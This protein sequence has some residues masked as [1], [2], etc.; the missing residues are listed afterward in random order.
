MHQSGE[1]WRPGQGRRVRLFFLERWGREEA[2]YADVIVELTKMGFSIEDLSLA[3]G[4]A[5]F[6]EDGEEAGM[7][8]EM[9]A[10]IYSS[11]VLI[12]PLKHFS[13][14]RDWAAWSVELAG[15]CYSVPVMLVELEEHAERRRKLVRPLQAVNAR[16]DVARPQ[17]FDI[18]FA[19]ARLLQRSPH[20]AIPD[21]AGD[22]RTLYRGP[23]RSALSEVM[24]LHPHRPAS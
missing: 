4:R 19:I 6:A 2:L 23:Q 8:G 15:L 1:A 9:A 14:P 11:D 13:G 24:R 21:R 18:A 17:A 20:Q 22:S 16:C 12:A 7:R 5:A 10:R 3:K